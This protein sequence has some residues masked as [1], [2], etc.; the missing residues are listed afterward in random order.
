MLPTACTLCRTFRTLR[1]PR[2]RAR[3][4]HLLLDIVA[5]AICGVICGCE[6]WAEIH[7]FAVAR[8]DWLKTFLRLPNGI[9][10]HD[11]LERV[12]D[13][14]DP[15]QFQV[16]FRAWTGALHAQLG[17]CPIAIDGKTLRSSGAGG[18]QNLHVV[19][20]WATTNGISLGQVAVD[21][22]SNE[23]TAIPQLL[24]LLDVHG[25]LVSV[26]ALGCQKEIAARIVDRGGDYVLTV[27]DNQ[28]TLR[29]AIETAFA[30]AA[31]QGSDHPGYSSCAT[32]ER[33]HGRVESRFYQVIEQAEWP[34]LEAWKQLKVIGMC[35]SETWREGKKSEE[36]RCFIGSR[37]GNAEM[38][39][40]AVRNHWSIENQLHWQ[41]D[42]NFGEDDNRYTKRHGAQNLASVRRLALSLLRQHPDKGSIACKRLHAALD[43][44]F[45]EEILQIDAK[46]GKV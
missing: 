43:P 14:L 39:G 45:L 11:T 34:G 20:A 5:I 36:V 37:R 17:L 16:C 3:T 26:D 44:Q 12:F 15:Q 2:V 29:A 31:D 33:G 32:E 23:I 38:Y 46:S 13:L 9:P 27:K 8:R 21:A 22:K 7:T 35:Y 10:S 25:A 30:E 28:P 42:V 41:L 4:R 6:D 1:D 19:S 24:Q 40:K 18:L